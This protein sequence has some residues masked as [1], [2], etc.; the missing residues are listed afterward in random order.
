MI[1]ALGAHSSLDGCY[2]RTQQDTW[3][4]EGPPYDSYRYEYTRLSI[5][6]QEDQ[7]VVTFSKKTIFSQTGITNLADTL[8]RIFAPS[9]ITHAIQRAAEDEHLVFRILQE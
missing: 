5:E 1:H 4:K 2:L 9:Y 6:N 7:I 3:W 8:P